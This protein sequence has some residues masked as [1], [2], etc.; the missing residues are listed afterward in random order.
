MARNL[1]GIKPRQARAPASDPQR[2][3]RH[4]HEI[5]T[6]VHS[7]SPSLGRDGDL[8]LVFGVGLQDELAYSVLCGALTD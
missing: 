4:H 1:K 6:S 8:F 3:D 5:F 2:D 7:T